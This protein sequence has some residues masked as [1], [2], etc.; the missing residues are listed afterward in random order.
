M[1][2]VIFYSNLFFRAN[3]SLLLHEPSVQA[4]LTNTMTC[5]SGSNPVPHHRNQEREL[6]R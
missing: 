6:I 4:S 3:N 5:V 1:L 2:N